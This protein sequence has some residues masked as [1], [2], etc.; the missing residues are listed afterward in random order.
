MLVVYV[1]GPF[2]AKN[3]WDME[4]NIRRAEEIALEVWRAGFACICPHVNTRF[5]QGAAPDSVWLE[6]DLAILKKCDAILMTPDWTKSTGA[7][8][9]HDFA[10]VPRIPVFYTLESLLHLEDEDF[11]R[12]D[13][14]WYGVTRALG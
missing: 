1:A 13:R 2:R 14:H 11:P 12:L 8:A 3:S 4:Q 7:K 6:G 5:F 10:L 9:E